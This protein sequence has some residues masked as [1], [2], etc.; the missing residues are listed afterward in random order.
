[1]MD[2]HSLALEETDSAP[3]NLED[4]TRRMDDAEEQR[5]D[6]VSY[7]ERNMQPTTEY[8]L[9]ASQDDTIHSLALMSPE[10]LEARCSELGRRVVDLKQEA[11]TNTFECQ[12]HYSFCFTYNR[13][14]L[15]LRDQLKN[16]PQHFVLNTDDP[17]YLVQATNLIAL[18]TERAKSQAE[19][20]RIMRRELVIF[21]DLKQT[22]LELAK[23]EGVED[24]PEIKEI[25]EMLAGRI[26]RQYEVRRH[27]GRRLLHHASGAG[28]I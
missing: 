13:R 4:L 3:A 10:S 24:M 6:H 1:M 17:T 22:Y 20:V 5:N 19:M 2:T 16:A 18:D 8:G 11:Y 12:T 15:R 27:F 14:Y 9:T 21:A 25:L 23:L 26:E 28:G 7:L